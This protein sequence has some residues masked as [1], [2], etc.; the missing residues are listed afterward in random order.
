MSIIRIN[1]VIDI[2][3]DTKLITKDQADKINDDIQK[4]NKRLHRPKELSEMFK[5][6]L[7]DNIKKSSSR[8]IEL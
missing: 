3:R 6:I 4:S 2:L 1:D 7:S 5:R 8:R